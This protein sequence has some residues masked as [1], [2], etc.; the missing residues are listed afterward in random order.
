LLANW[1]REV[2][3]DPAEDVLRLALLAPGA[4]VPAEE[5]L[6]ELM[7]VGNLAEAVEAALEDDEDELR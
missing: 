5:L 2:L 7:Q 4:S 6:E 3:V 1:P